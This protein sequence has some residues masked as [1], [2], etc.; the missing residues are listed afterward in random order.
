MTGFITLANSL[1]GL[2]VNRT[3]SV[4]VMESGVAECTPCQAQGSLLSVAAW[5]GCFE[6]VEWLLNAEADVNI[7]DKVGD[8][9]AR[10]NEA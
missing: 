5:A 1:Y 2:D 3:F 7:P 4:S 8:Q 9:K 6:V 10:V